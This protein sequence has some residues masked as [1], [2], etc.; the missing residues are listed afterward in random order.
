MKLALPN[1][2]LI[3]IIGSEN[4]LE[5]TIKAIKYSCKNIEFGSVKLLSN[6]KVAIEN[7]DIIE[8]QS[9]NREQ[10]A[11]FCIYDLPKYV[12]TEFCLTVQH[13]GF[14]I[15][16]DLWNDEFLKF[17]YI[18]A[19]WLNERWNNVGNG[20]FSLRSKKFLQAASTL[21]YNSKIQF[22]P[23]IAAGE[24]IT[25]EDWFICN[26]SYKQML[27][28]NIKFA[29]IKTARKF[30]VEHPSEYCHTL[31]NTKISSQPIK[32]YDPNNIDSYHSFG[33]HGEFNAGAMKLLEI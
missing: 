25:P 17:D 10:Y 13:D 5:N 29:D 12:N 26:Y 19:P 21:S 1:V 16:P 3:S 18:G 33:F 6:K 2:T 23:H 28:M 11:N 30:S 20:G 24:L 32:N 27:D 8:I 22:Q 9:L 14:I 15:N 7:I 31:I 4:Y